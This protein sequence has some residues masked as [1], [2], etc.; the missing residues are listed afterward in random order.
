MPLVPGGGRGAGRGIIMGVWGSLRSLRATTVVF[1]EC[2]SY[3]QRCSCSARM[4]LSHMLYPQKLY[5]QPI[6][7]TFKDL[8]WM[9][10]I[11]S[12]LFMFL[13]INICGSWHIS[14]LG[15]P[16]VQGPDLPVAIPNLRPVLVTS[17]LLRDQGL[18][19]T[20]SPLSAVTQS[21]A[22]SFNVSAPQLRWRVPTWLL[23]Y[24]YVVLWA[25]WTEL[26]VILG[27][28]W[29][30]RF[31]FLLP[32]IPSILWGPIKQSCLPT[33]WCHSTSS[34]Q[35]Y[36]KSLVKPSLKSCN[37]LVPCEDIG[38]HMSKA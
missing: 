6:H 32:W 7:W 33:T 28:V 34:T 20:G 3:V 25:Y 35:S 38:Q 4:E 9:H 15:V 21:K 13:S 12:R 2:M 26:N 5:C 11:N 19:S 24:F 31:F 30:T 27:E 29:V 22:E 36:N 16:V 14:M 8:P 1:E 23:L 37:I 10:F 18:S 17:T